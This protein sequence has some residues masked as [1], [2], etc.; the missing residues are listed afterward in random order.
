MSDFKKWTPADAQREVLEALNAEAEKSASVAEFCR[1]FGLFSDSKFSKILDALD[2]KRERSYFDDV[3]NP[4]GLMD[5]LADWLKKIPALRLEKETAA[6]RDL[7][8]LSKFRAVA[9]AVRECKNESSPERIVK[10]ISPTGGGKTSLRRWLMAEFKGELSPAYVES[11]EAWR[12]ATRDLRQRA[13]L[14]VLTD[15]ARALGLRFTARMSRNDVAGIEDEL[16]DY[17]TQTRRLLFIDEAEFFSGYALNLVKLLLNKSRLIVVI[18]CTPRAHA[19]WNSWY[20]DEADQI[21][22]RTHAVVSVSSDDLETGALKNTLADAALF[23]PGDQFADAVAA[24]KYVVEQAWTFGHYSTVAR[25]ARELEKH[26]HAE[27][28]IVEAAVSKA[29]RQMAKERAGSLRR[30]Q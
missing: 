12:P 14:V 13:K 18:A 15:I 21:S 17:C 23:F 30:P 10:F 9:V 24:L 29:L 5:E 27:K 25:V 3:K 22:R 1:D 2:P 11:R 6:R 7:H 20:A 28:A 8:K 19:K 4:E 26:T 16:I